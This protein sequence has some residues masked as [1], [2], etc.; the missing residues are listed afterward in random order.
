[1]TPEEFRTALIERGF[2]FSEKKSLFIGPYNVHVE[3]LWAYDRRRGKDT[4]RVE[5]LA[6]IDEILR[7]RRGLPRPPSSGGPGAGL[8]SPT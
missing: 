2:H 3:G 4:A 6:R 8:Y 1:M 5:E 7:D